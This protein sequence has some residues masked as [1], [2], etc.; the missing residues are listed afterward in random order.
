MVVAIDGPAGVGKSTIAFLLAQKL[1]FI[2]LDSG[3]IY[4][5]LAYIAQKQALN[6]ENI[7]TYLTKNPNQI[8]FNYKN[9]Q[10]QIFFQKEDIAQ[11]IR[12]K[13]ITSSTKYFANQLKCRHFVNNL[14]K[15]TAKKFSVIIDGRDI[16]SI[17]FP[18]AKCKIY[19]T[20][21]TKVRA[22]RRAKEKNISL[23][24]KDFQILKKDLMQRDQQDYQRKIA[25][26]KKSD[27]AILID[28]SFLDKTQVIEKIYQII[29]QKSLLP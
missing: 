26:L 27:D 29:Q 10:Q 25:P 18:E 8:A 5:T 11:K 14:L 6:P 19:L 2:H 1:K 28:T 22:I 21:N 24:S 23:Q 13:S 17:V 16:G 3:A 15:K 12:E 20:A 9:Y 4:R 7:A